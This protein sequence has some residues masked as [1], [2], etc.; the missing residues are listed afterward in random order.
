MYKGLTILRYISEYV[1]LGYSKMLLL[2][3]QE[4][5]D[6]DKIHDDV[7][8]ILR[9]REISRLD[10]RIFIGML[11]FA[12]YS[13][14]LIICIQGLGLTW[15]EK[16]NVEEHLVE[17]LKA[18]REHLNVNLNIEFKGDP[19]R[20]WYSLSKE[21]HHKLFRLLIQEKDKVNNLFKVQL[22]ALKMLLSS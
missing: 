16:H 19:K 13:S 21:V 12:G 9:T 7:R 3:D 22:T 4:D 1:R 15:Y 17:A 8:R 14:R 18:L 5:L 11:N 6:L 20:I 2:V 10:E